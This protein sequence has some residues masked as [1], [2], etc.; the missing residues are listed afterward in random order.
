[1]T[2]EKQDAHERFTL[3]YYNRNPRPLG[4]VR[5]GLSDA[6]H[7]S[8]NVMAD[9]VKENTVRGRLTI[10]GQHM[11]EAV[12]RVSEAI[13]ALREKLIVKEQP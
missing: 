7:M 12:Y 6:A 2:T 3:D 13:W 9:I 4:P 1:M 10:K 11:H 8:D 5:S